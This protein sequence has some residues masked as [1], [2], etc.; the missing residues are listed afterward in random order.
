MGG[1]RLRTSV[2][3][4]P[5]PSF[6][7]IHLKGVRPIMRNVKRLHSPPTA[8]FLFFFFPFFIDRIK[9][10]CGDETACYTFNITYKQ[11][12]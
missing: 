3:M 5:R 1:N 9:N 6:M 12:K 2:V 10:S 7:V 11:N 8:G 4:Q